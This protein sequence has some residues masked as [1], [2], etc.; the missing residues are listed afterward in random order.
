[1]KKAKRVLLIALTLAITLSIFATTAQAASNNY[2][3]STPYYRIGTGKRL[4]IYTDNKMAGTGQ[5]YIKLGT[6]LLAPYATVT[7]RVQDL[8]SGKTCIATLRSGGKLYLEIDHRYYITDISQR[9]TNILPYDWR[10]V[11]TY[12]VSRIDR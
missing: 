7:L 12:R 2:S 9:V 1:M 11:T 4:D 6:S 8:T 5:P 10:L 3:I